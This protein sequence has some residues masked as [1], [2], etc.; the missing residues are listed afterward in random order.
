M[1]KLAAFIV[2]VIMTVLRASGR[3]TTLPRAV[4]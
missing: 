3:K 2:I 1:K 4:W